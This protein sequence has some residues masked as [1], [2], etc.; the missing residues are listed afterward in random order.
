MTSGGVVEVDLRALLEKSRAA[1]KPWLAPLSFAKLAK[2]CGVS[3]AH[4][5]ALMNGTKE[6]SAQTL[7][8]LARGLRGV[9][10]GDVLAAWSVTEANAAKRRRKRKPAGGVGGTETPSEVPKE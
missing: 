1:R 9:T 7:H 8:K 2:R 10:F 6:P 3:R 4:L 5:Y